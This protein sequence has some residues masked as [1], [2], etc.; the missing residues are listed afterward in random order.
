MKKNNNNNHT[1]AIVGAGD[2]GSTAAYALVLSHVPADI[3]LVDID[4]QRCAGELLDLRDAIAFN[5]GIC[6][7]VQGTFQDVRYADIIIIA[8]GVRQKPDQKRTDLLSTNCQVVTHI[9]DRIGPIDSETVV[10]MVTNPVDLLTRHAMQYAG[11]SKTQIIGT[12]TFIDTKRLTGL[13][14]AQLDI[15][16]PSINAYIIGEHGDTQFPVWSLA[17]IA[18]MPIAS[19]CTQK[20]L[21]LLARNARERS[22][23]IISCKG[24][25]YFGI[26][27]CIARLC[28]A[29]VY[30][31]KMIVPVSCYQQEFELCLSMP[32][33]L[34][35]KGVEQVLPL[36]LSD[37]EKKLLHISVQALAT[38]F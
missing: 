20:D 34:G 23:E 29:I 3:I 5:G 4:E 37:G 18:G 38:Y 35:K 19:F 7:V 21:D 14:S 32:V 16:E 13:I 28:Q 6:S 22:Y 9:F 31:Q 33:I 11:L 10:I 15:A 26:A 30:D 1:I 17:C 24:A 2:V 8:A 27:T 36:P 25:T 12:G